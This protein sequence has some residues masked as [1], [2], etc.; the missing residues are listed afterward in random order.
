MYTRTW[1]LHKVQFVLRTWN[2][3]RQTGRLEGQSRGIVG[4][5][6][7]ECLEGG[8]AD[9]LADYLAEAEGGFADYLA[10]ATRRF[11]AGEDSSD[12]GERDR[13]LVERT[14]LERTRRSQ[15]T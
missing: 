10:E 9:Y 4:E 15:Q 3:L 14:R 8:F 1:K 13:G 11:L 12:D 2:A 5:T 6:G 7:A